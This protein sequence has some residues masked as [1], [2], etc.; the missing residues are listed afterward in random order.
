MTFC[1]TAEDNNTWLLTEAVRYPDPAKFDEPGSKTWKSGP[2][3]PV[4]NKWNSVYAGRPFLAQAHEW[5][6]CAITETFW[7]L[8]ARKE[9]DEPQT[10]VEM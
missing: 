4:A 3:I 5:L 8:S 9:G 6:N 10:F 2:V 1:D 7:D